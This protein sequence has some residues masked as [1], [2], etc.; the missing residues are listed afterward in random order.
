M[1]AALHSLGWGDKGLQIWTDWSRTC[2]E[3]YDAADQQKTWESFDRPYDGPRITAAT[4]FFEARQQGWAEEKS[5]DEYHTDLG[6]ARRFVKRHGENIRFVPE[7]RT[8]LVWNE[9]R[10]V[11]DTDGAVMRLAKDTVEALYPDALQSA[12]NGDRDALLKHAI[13]SQAEARLRAMVSLA[14]SETA[15]VVAAHKL[16]ANPWLVGVRNGVIDLMT[17]QFRAAR[18]Q[19]LITKCLHVEFDPQARC[20]QWLKFLDTVTGRDRSLRSYIQRVVGYA[21]SGSVREEAMFVLYGTGSNGKSTFRETL[22][23][24]CGDY[25]LAADASL[26]TERKKA[27]GATEEIA[28]LK[29]RR[30]VAVNE[31]AENDQLNE[32]RV[33][34]ITSQDMITA[35]NL[36]GHFFDFFPTHKTFLTTNHKPIV[37][38]TDEGIWR[39][40]QLIPF[41]V[42]IAKKAVEKDFRERRLMPEL[43]GIV[44]WAL[45]GLAAYRKHGLNPPQKVLASTES[46]RQDMD[47]VGQWI[48]ERC[49]QNP[50]ASVPTSVAYGDYSLWAEEEV[51]WAREARRRP[52]RCLRSRGLTP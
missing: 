2:T 29:G 25:A 26:L 45:L 20:P 16:D 31:T 32:S 50:N 10:W 8:W 27:G 52:Q 17:G 9:Y 40:V 34:F 3:Q 47:V 15:V 30:F 18:R 11:I 39:R 19:D 7:W 49:E 21:L 35:R 46:Y 14:E 38:G 42:T 22:H 33:K 28:R 41:T 44:N 36:Y 37:R 23:A 12:S 51:G 1:G 43:P 13:R 24:L 5:A 6:N 48:D 4:I